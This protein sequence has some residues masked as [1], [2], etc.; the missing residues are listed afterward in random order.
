MLL[1]RM[2]EFSGCPRNTTTNQNNFGCFAYNY[3]CLIN[4]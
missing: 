2:I 3:F 1:E 4:E